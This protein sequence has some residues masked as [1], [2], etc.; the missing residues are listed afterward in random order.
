M[1]KMY[2]EVL[3][4]TKQGTNRNKINWSKSVEFIIKFIYENIEGEV[5]IVE[6]NSKKQYLYIKYLNEDNFKISITG[7]KDCA[8]G[9]LLGIKSDKFKKEIGDTLKSKNRDLVITNR[10]YRDSPYNIGKKLKWYKYT[11][12]K[13]G[14]TEG[15]VTENNL[16]KIK[17]RGCACCSNHKSVLGI[18]TMWDTS[19]WMCNLGVSEKDA[20]EYN[21]TSNKK[22]IVTCP[23]CGREK[24]ITIYDIYYN[25]SIA[26]ICGDNFSYPEKLFFN[27]LEQINIDFKWQLTKTTFEWCKDYRYDFY[28]PSINCIIETHG[29]QHYKEHSRNSKFDRSLKEE[30][31]NDKNKK[32]LAIK[33][34]IEKENYIVIDCRKSDLEFIK[35]KIIHSRLNELYD[36]NKIDWLKCHEYALCNLVKE[37]CEYKNN[38]PNL[39][40][41]D[42]GKIMKLTHPTVRGYL[43]KGSILNWCIYDIKKE[44]KNNKK[45]VEIFKNN[46]SLGVF[47]SCSKLEKQSEKLFGV[48]LGNSGISGV[49]NNKRLLY[50][51]FT[52]KFVIEQNNIIP[53]PSEELAITLVS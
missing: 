42:I 23:D 8:L 15:W 18:N 38:N 27:V 51:G 47:E 19:K 26:C 6:Y 53:T 46:I 28:V 52:F 14:W 7:F 32:E 37:A 10:E 16:L 29:G 33:N 43:K 12:N 21:K 11:C 31:K 30:Q 50:K 20:K 39:S 34:G 25:H 9:N 41:L 35:Y 17:E 13:C 3:P 4:L 1:R 45:P 5:K 22:I 44:Q 49:C 24:K 48:K 2:Y 36:L 40:T